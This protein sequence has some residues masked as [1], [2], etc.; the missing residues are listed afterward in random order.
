MQYEFSVLKPSQLPPLP[1]NANQRQDISA[2][3]LYL[4]AKI[5]ASPR[6]FRS[7]T[8]VYAYL[9][10]RSSSLSSSTAENDPSS[11][12]LSETAYITYR[13]RLLNIEG[14]VLNAL[15]FNTHV[16]LPHPLAI[17]YLQILDVFSTSHRKGAG[18]AVAKRTLQYLNSALLSPQMLY[19]THQPCALAVAAIYLAAKEEGVKMPE[20]EW[21]EVFDVEREELGF[22]VV[23]MRS[24]EGVARRGKDVFGDVAVVTREGVRKQLAA[25]GGG[26]KNGAGGGDEEDEMMRMMDEKMGDA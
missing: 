5:S 11:Y 1:T 16:A 15:G 12:Y 21:W 25:S 20:N 14:Q 2:A 8:N 3:T 19:L 22:L 23:G 13:T 10:S 9:L 24:V 18:K 17:T 26:E 7:I 4:T 6:S